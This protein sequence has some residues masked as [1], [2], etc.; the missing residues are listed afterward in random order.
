MN[1]WKQSNTWEE[2]FGK[3]GLVIIDVDLFKTKMHDI[4]LLRDKLSA[5]IFDSQLNEIHAR[6]AILNKFSELG[7]HHTRV[8]S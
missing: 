2:P 3:K 1:Y 6:E 7:Q 8:A 4:K 5:N